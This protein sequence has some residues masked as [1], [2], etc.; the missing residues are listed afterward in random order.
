MHYWRRN[1][2]RQALG[3]PAAAGQGTPRVW[4]IRTG[5]PFFFFRLQRDH[6]CDPEVQFDHLCD[7][8]VQLYHLYDLGVHTDRIPM[9]LGQYDGLGE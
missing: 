9:G 5:I 1:N 6:L 2:A 8:E 4:A 3:G 7:I